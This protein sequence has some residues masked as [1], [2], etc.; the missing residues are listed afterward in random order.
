[1]GLK[2]DAALQ[3]ALHEGWTSACQLYEHL[4]AGGDLAVLPPG[5]VRLNPG[6]VA[7]ADTVLG[8]ARF[9]GMNVTYQQH[10]TLLLGSAGFVAAG[11]TANMI[12]N[13]SA[14]RRAEAQ[15]AGQWR[16]H[17]HVR[18]ILTNHRLLCDYGGQWLSFWHEGIVEFQGDL[19]QWLFVL[20]Y[21]VGDPV[22][23]HGPGAPWFAVAVAHLG[24][25]RPGLQLPGLMVL[26]NAVA[27]AVAQRRRAIEG[28]VVAGTGGDGAPT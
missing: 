27:D 11:L 15:A 9:Y 6:E 4:H 12:A 19:A 13:S 25:G 3:A 22:L 17:A 26:A 5:P 14:R 28:E 2:K 8:Y 24:Y 21:E 1:M 18:T 20:R 10:S 16:D 7:Y 23:L